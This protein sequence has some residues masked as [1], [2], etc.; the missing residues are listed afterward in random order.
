[1]L[2]KYLFTFDIKPI[3]QDITKHVDLAGWEKPLI[4]RCHSVNSRK[5]AFSLLQSLCTTHPQLVPQVITG[6]YS[7]LLGQVRKPKKAGYQPKFD[8]RSNNFAGL[9]NLGSIYMNSVL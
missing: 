1:V 3:T 7:T 5:A 4:N 2:T 9:R 8:T 6:Y